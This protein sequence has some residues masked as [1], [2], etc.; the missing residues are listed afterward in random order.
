MPSH[1]IKEITR[2]ELR[3]RAATLRQQAE[4]RQ[5][6]LDTSRSHETR[7]RLRA[8]VDVM[9]EQAADYEYLAAER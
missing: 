2:A 6:K 4:I 7:L 8:E 1:T 9:R 5:L 3:L